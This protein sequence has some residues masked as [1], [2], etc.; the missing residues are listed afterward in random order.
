MFGEFSGDVRCCGGII[1][2]AV[3]GSERGDGD[4]IDVT[5]GFVE[6]VSKG[7]S[8]DTFV[9]SE[10]KFL[11]LLGSDDESDGAHLF[12]VHHVFAGSFDI[13]ID[14]EDGDVLEESDGAS[15]AGRV[16]GAL[17]VHGEDYV[18]FISGHDEAGDAG[19]DVWCLNGDSAESFGD[20][21]RESSSGT[22]FSESSG[23]EELSAGEVISG[24]TSDCIFGFADGVFGDGIDGEAADAEV[25]SF[26]DGAPWEVFGGDDDFLRCG[27]RVSS[28]L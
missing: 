5:E 16:I 11:S 21:W 23:D 9:L 13:L 10:V 4:L 28:L 26:E 19:A 15:A 22:G 27:S 20:E 17:T 6:W 7:E 18:D 1:E 3:V 12:E 14:G 2:I 24:G 25:L 8:E